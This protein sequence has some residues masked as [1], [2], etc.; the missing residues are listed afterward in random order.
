VEARP[1]P[2]GLLRLDRACASR[3]D[4]SVNEVGHPHTSRK[5]V[6]HDRA[7]RRVGR[8]CAASYARRCLRLPRQAGFG[9][10]AAGALGARARPAR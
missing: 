1:A 8:A 6:E 10:H 5:T 2:S 3:W 9:R 7:A 4:T